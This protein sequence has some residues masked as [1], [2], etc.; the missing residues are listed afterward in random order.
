MFDQAE[1][2][3]EIS[4]AELVRLVDRVRAQ[5]KDPDRMIVLLLAD[6]RGIDLEAIVSRLGSG[7]R[8]TGAV[9]PALLDGNGLRNRGALAL[10]ASVAIERAVLRDPFAPPSVVEAQAS[11]LLPSDPAAPIGT[12]FVLADGQA[13][14]GADALL[15]GLRHP[16][17]DRGAQF[18]GGGA[19]YWS[20]SGGPSLFTESE[21]LQRGA[22]VVLRLAAQSSV[23]VEHGWSA[24]AGPFYASRCDNTTVVELNWRRAIDVYQ[25]NLGMDLAHPIDPD[26]FPALAA[27][28]PL[29][30]LK[31]KDAMVVRDPMVL[32]EEGGLFTLGTIPEHSLVSILKAEPDALIRA[33]ASA[34][35]NAN[36]KVSALGSAATSAFVFD[37]VSRV[38]VLG[39]HFRDELG[40]V[41]KGIAAPVVG[42]LSLG[43]IASEGGVAPE[44]H[45]KTIVIGCR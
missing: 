29:A 3:D 8:V 34:A 12:L 19:G 26:T 32:T 18:I 11:V 6:Q 38:D 41:K 21:V 1:F 28:H 37:C 35:K 44:F 27:H 5:G 36:D 42:A 31:M 30:V 33:A 25:Q 7:R 14:G 15:Q 10:S 43:E 20:L 16:F 13:A 9:F 45:N 40:E 39:T 22:A 24:L 4:P 17:V 23:A 2:T